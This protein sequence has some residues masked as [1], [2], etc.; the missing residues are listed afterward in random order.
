MYGCPEAAGLLAAKGMLDPAPQVWL[1]FFPTILRPSLFV[2][3][4]SVV[5]AE[6]HLHLDSISV[7]SRCHVPCVGQE[8]FAEEA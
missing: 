3:R 7:G 4:T 1:P 6:F 8:L 5:L 2:L